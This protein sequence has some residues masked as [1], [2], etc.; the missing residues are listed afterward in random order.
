[1]IGREALELVERQ[2][3]VPPCTGGSSLSMSPA[4]PELV[5]EILG[6]PMDIFR[7]FHRE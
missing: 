1:V 7:L 4:R 5:F 6:C 2:Q 3:R